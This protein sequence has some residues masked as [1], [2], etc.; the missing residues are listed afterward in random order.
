M[1]KRKAGRRWRKWRRR[2]SRVRAWKEEEEGDDRGKE[3][4]MFV[5][6]C[7]LLLEHNMGFSWECVCVFVCVFFR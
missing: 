3:Q 1:E 5:C 6:F 4:G 7:S 2:R